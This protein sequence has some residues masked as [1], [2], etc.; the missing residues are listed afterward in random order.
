MRCEQ[1]S[2]KC[3]KKVLKFGDLLD[4]FEKLLLY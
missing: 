2:E 1:I 4:F 3:I